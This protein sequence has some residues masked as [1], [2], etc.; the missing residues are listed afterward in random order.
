[1]IIRTPIFMLLAGLVLLASGCSRSRAAPFDPSAT[2]PAP[3][4][5]SASGSTPGLAAALVSQATAG[6]ANIAVATQPVLLVTTGTP[7]TPAA[8][9]PIPTATRSRQPSPVSDLIYLA[10]DRL[11]RWDPLTRHAI[12]LAQNVAGFVA[13]ADGRVILLLRP[14]N[15]TANGAQRYKLEAL[16]LED[17]QIV[18]LFD[19]ASQPGQILASPD[20]SLVA[21]TQSLTGGET[22]Y[23]LPLDP[24]SKPQKLGV[25]QPAPAG[26]CAALAWSPDSQSLLWSDAQGLWQASTT[27][28]ETASKA[29]LVHPNKV[30]V[31]DP[32]GQKVE[33]EARFTGLQFAPSER[34][35]RLKVTPLDS[36]VGWQAVF[37][38]RSGQLAGAQDTYITR[39]VDAQTIWQSNGNLLV[40][41]ASDPS[42]QAPPFIHTWY[43]MPTNPELLVSGEQLDLYSD[44]FPFSAAQSKAIPAHCLDWLAEIQPNHLVFGV[45]LDQSDN[46]PVLFD[47]N[48]L[49]KNLTKVLELPADTTQVLWSPDGV[50]ALVLGGRNQISLLSVKSGEMIDLQTTLGLNAQQFHWL[51]PVLRR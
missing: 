28:G 29:Q 32:K 33:M 21:F 2:P 14:Q 23:L 17:Q 7:A 50:N 6:P 47:L 30:Q 16:R 46:P 25:C 31:L 15:I 8:E 39:A 49:T 45:Q 22:I 12:P 11:M 48:L 26:E 19:D 51:P 3:A 41:H 9:A 18:T 20:G 1:V 44:D 35:V 13:S 43:V 42:R 5:G 36:Q 34:F 37:D 27:V 38:R 40:A 10:A 24:G 4:Q